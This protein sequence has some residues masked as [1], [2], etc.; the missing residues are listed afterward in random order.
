MTTLAST[1]DAPRPVPA[2]RAVPAV[3]VVCVGLVLAGLVSYAVRGASLQ[4]L[5]D[6][7]VFQ[8]APVALMSVTVFGIAVRRHPANAAAWAFFASGVAASVHVAS[9]AMV[10]ATRDRLPD[11]WASVWSGELAIRDLPASVGWPLWVATSVWLVSAGL[12]V[13]GL[14]LFPDGRLPSA[15][16]RPAQWLLVG[17]L[18][19]A[20]AGWVWSYRTWSPHPVEFNFIPPDDR[21]ANLLLVVGMPALGVG[22]LLT[23]ASLAA[24]L[25]A[26][27]PDERRRVRPVVVAAVLFVATMVLLYPWQAVWAVATIPA[28]VLAMAVV[29]ASV[30]RHRFFDVEFVVSRAV[31]VAALGAVVT[32][33]YVG[34][35]AGLGAL[36]GSGSRVWLS[37]GA[38]ALIAVVFEPLRR[39]ILRFATRLVTGT[40][41]TPEEVLAALSDQLGR[42]DSTDEVLASVV[43]LLVAATGAGRAEVRLRRAD[44]GSPLDAA[45]GEPPSDPA[46]RAVP[47][48]HAGDTLGEVRLLAAREDRFLPADDRLLRRVAAA[49]GPVARNARLTRELQQHIDELEASRQRLVTA[50]DDARRALERDI[51]DGAQQQ[52]LSLR[53]RLGLAVTLAER[54]GAGG[55]AQ[56]LAEAGSQADDAIR[57]LRDLARGLYPPVLA[58]QGLAAALRAHARELPLPVTVE[59]DGV[60]VRDRQVEAAAYFCCLEALHN[61]T[62]HAAAS[63]LHVGLREVDGTLDFAVTDDGKGFEPAAVGAGAGL[64]NMRDRVEGLGGTL[65]VAAAPDG[66]TVVRGRIPV[67]RAAARGRQPAVSDR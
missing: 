62:R 45:V 67:G 32:L 24:R 19:V 5:V 39:R 21:V 66:G 43:D 49:L 2:A 34:V 14:L 59:A 42:A 27:E 55:V 52:L 6:A 56:V 1:L 37:L 58:E 3:A 48:V 7:W 64:V 46:H 9:M 4:E 30:T 50:H 26:A 28:I 10:F 40:R 47:I 36:L 23:V 16:W 17:G 15:R 51:H 60:R 54:E 57:Q 38:T 53:L 25:R 8:N 33:T 29:A 35:V 41:T 18:L 31:T 12:A 22:A 20:E 44:G 65:E 11:L 13:L 61:A 63:S